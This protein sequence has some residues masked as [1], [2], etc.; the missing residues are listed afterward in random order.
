[1]GNTKILTKFIFPFIWRGNWIK[2]C[3]GFNLKNVGQ[4]SLINCKR[5]NAPVLILT[6]DPH[7]LVEFFKHKV[8]QP[9]ALQLSNN[10][11][12]ALQIQCV[13]ALFLATCISLICHHPWG[14]DELFPHNCSNSFTVKWAAPECVCYWD[15]MIPA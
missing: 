10:C 3:P 13:W 11:S 12:M 2:K 7:C 15:Q 8:T 14:H 9:G 4:A 1:M 5:W 6:A